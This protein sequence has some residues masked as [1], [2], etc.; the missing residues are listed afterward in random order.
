LVK[1]E[2][3]SGALLVQQHGELDFLH[4]GFG[5]ANRFECS[6]VISEKADRTSGF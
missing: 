3:C 2:H 4:V 6:E 1:A 5:Q